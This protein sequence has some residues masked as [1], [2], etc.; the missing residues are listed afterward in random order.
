MCVCLC[1]S[2]YLCKKNEP[3]MIL[4]MNLYFSIIFEALLFSWNDFQLTIAS[5]I[6][7]KTGL[8]TTDVVHFMNNGLYSDGTKC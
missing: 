5:F 1:V 2:V 8:R 3:E 7:L 6:D 4:K